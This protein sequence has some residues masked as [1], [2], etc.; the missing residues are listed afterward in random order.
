MCTLYAAAGSTGLTSS[1]ICGGNPR[2]QA[3]MDAISGQLEIGSSHDVI[4]RTPS[5]DLAVALSVP[6]RLEPDDDLRIA[7]DFGRTLCDY[8]R[9]G[10]E[11]QLWES[12]K[13]LVLEVEGFL[14]AVCT[15]VGG[16]RPNH[17][18]AA[19]WEH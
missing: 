11:P 2:L 3:K 18:G 16:L 19:G 12:Q 1:A 5:P 14:A 4:V 10:I 17:R 13:Q 6:P 8:V 15:L 7:E 9:G